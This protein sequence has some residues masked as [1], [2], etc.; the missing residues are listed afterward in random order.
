MMENFIITIGRQA[1]SGGREVGMRLAQ[2]LGIP[3][4]GRQELMQ[5]AKG[6]PDYEEVQSFYE[7]QPVDSLL[8]ALA[9]INSED[10]LGHIPFQR[11]RQLCSK[12]SCV[13][14]GRCGGYIFRGQER[15]VS[16]F[17]HASENIRAQR[18]MK[19][20][21]LSLKKAVELNQQTDSDRAAFH[22]YYTREEWGASAHYDLCLDSGILGVEGTV[23]VI[24]AYL[25]IR[26][27]VQ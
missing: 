1:G 23:E 7:E 9:T 14:I 8:Y 4:Y 26:G 22:R 21:G 18:T 3:Y 16:I 11:I 10:E 20:Y 15:A 2:R 17:L 13:L 12:T 5:I 27:I 25:K 19:D 24:L 6:T